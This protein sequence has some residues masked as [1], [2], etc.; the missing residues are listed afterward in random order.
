MKKIIK[1]GVMLA[2]TGVLA[3]PM[4]SCGETN[5]TIQLK[6]VKQAKNVI[7]MIGDGMGQIGRAHV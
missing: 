5:K 1:Q 3:F 4:I 6:N 7:L 2:L